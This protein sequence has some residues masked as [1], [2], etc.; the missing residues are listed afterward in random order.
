MDKNMI[1]PF[2]DGGLSRESVDNWKGNIY[3][4]FLIYSE[5]KLTLI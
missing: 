5:I 2:L 4:E 1:S 3:H